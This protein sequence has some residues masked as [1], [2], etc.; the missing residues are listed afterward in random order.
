[1]ESTRNSHFHPVTVRL[2]WA[3]ESTCSDVMAAVCKNEV[4]HTKNGSAL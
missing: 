3:F 2:F 4:V 1:M